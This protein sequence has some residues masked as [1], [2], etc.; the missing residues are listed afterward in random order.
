MTTA[1]STP[2]TDRSTMI[3]TI[4]IGGLLVALLH[5]FLGQFLL[6]S[7]LWQTPYIYTLQQISSGLMG[8]AAFAGGIATALLGLLLHVFISLTM[9]TVFVLIANR[10]AWLRRHL[11]V[12]GLLY[13]L[14]AMLVMGMIVIPLSALPPTPPPPNWILMIGLIEHPVA[15]GLPLALVYQRMT[16]QPT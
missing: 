10:W 1:T 15:A 14:G 7:V 16:N 5:T 2:I 6:L 4:L 8:E 9:A 12:G 13:G 11:I 3:R